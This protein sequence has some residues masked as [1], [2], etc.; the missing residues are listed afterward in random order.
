MGAIKKPLIV[1][2]VVLIV[3]IIVGIV[4]SYRNQNEQ[5]LDEYRDDSYIEDEDY[6]E[7]T[8]SLHKVDVPDGYI[9]IYTVDDFDYMRTNQNSNFILM[10]DID[11]SSVKN[12]ESPN[13]SGEFDGNNYTISNYNSNCSFFNKIN[14]E[15]RDFSIIDSNIDASL[16]KDIQHLI[17]GIAGSL[18][19]DASITNCTYK[20]NI[21]CNA[22]LTGHFKDRYSYMYSGRDEYNFLVGG[23]VASSNGIIESSMFEG[24]ITVNS[25]LYD[26]EVTCDGVNLFVGGLAGEVSGENSSVNNSTSRGSISYVFMADDSGGYEDLVGGCIGFVTGNGI[27]SNLTNEC[28]INFDDK[29]KKEYVW[30]SIGGIIGG[31]AS[32]DSVAP[33]I[34]SCSNHGNIIVTSLGGKTRL[35]GIAGGRRLY[36]YRI[37]QIINCYNTGNLTGDY[38]GGISGGND[39]SG[40]SII[41]FSYN[42]GQLNGNQKQGNIF[43]E[44]SNQTEPL[45]CYYLSNGIDVTGDKVKFP[46]VKELG[47]S[48][49][50]KQSSFEGFDFNDVWEMGKV[51]YKYPVLKQN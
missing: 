38:V 26:F 18:S 35:G 19:S 47:K 9:G 48:D 14:G 46:Y 29:S 50:E 16:E 40:T 23:I 49:M 10:N 8:E 20:G 27:L 45:Y 2:C 21:V 1:M 24:N 3:G 36:G 6:N 32:G 37:P 15:L 17:S 43:A 31:Y 28:I 30:T 39:Y 22:N 12:W 41:N 25:N 5:Y 13:I 4:D 33:K 7:I 42:V 11:F 44:F 34:Q 51:E